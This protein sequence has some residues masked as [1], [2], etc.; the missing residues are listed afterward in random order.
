MVSRRNYFVMTVMMFVL[1]FL[2]MSTRVF[3]TKGREQN[4]VLASELPSR[5]DTWN[6]QTGEQDAP[7]FGAD[8]SR[9][10]VLVAEKDSDLERMVQQWCTYTKRKL[11][12]YDSLAEVPDSILDQIGVLLLQPGLVDW[13]KDG[14]QVMRGAEKGMHTILCG[15]PDVSALR[16][17]EEWQNILGI[18]SIARDFTP[19]KGVKMFTGFMLGGEAI[20]Q[21]RDEEDVF[22]QDLG[23]SVPWYTLGRG[24]K[25]YM[26]GL[27][28]EDSDVKNEELPPLLWR[29][30]LKEGFTFVVNDEYMDDYVALGILD[31]IMAEVGSYEL[32][33]VVN[34][35]NVSL[36]NYPG[37]ANENEEQMM[38]I[39]SRNQQ[40]VYQEVITTGL[41]S[42]IRKGGWKM[43]ALITPQ[44][45]YLDEHE[46]DGDLLDFYLEEFYAE[47]M[48]VGLSLSTR[49]ATSV[50]DKV[51]RDYR[52]FQ[53]QGEIPTFQAVYA[54]QIDSAR[55]ASVKPLCSDMR[56]IIYPMSVEENLLSYV[57]DKVTA[58][59]LTSDGF[60]TSFSA[61]LQARSLQTALAYSNIG[62]NMNTVIWPESEADYWENIYDKFTRNLDFLTGDFDD[63]EKTTISESDLKVRR[64]LNLDYEDYRDSSAIWLTVKNLDEEAWFLLRTHGEKV[65]SVQG[66]EAYRLEDGA[67]LLRLTSEKVRIALEPDTLPGMLEY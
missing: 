32:Y 1:L 12:R 52:F 34:A 46:P 51:T 15:F 39:Y 17:N 18:S 66:G 24:T 59:S 37:F 8:K 21:V 55:I 38:E 61:L 56:T 13:E 65:E 9:N 48:E 58:Q 23:L 62:M 28:G 2:F 27:F 25:V 44:V 20:Y 7:V 50:L 41:I 22:E 64:F 47:N 42:S 43:T 26:V 67:F 54:D 57:E 60:E 10:V 35:Q 3:Q 40:A 19:I 11:S 4:G 49:P 30:H 29:N 16:S 45:N 5:E 14:T 53:E 63:F 6:A 31:S 36:I 33:P